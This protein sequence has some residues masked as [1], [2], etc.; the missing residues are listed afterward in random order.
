MVAEG[1]LRFGAA[2]PAD[3]RCGAIRCCRARPDPAEPCTP[4]N[5]ARDIRHLRSGRTP[6]R[7]W[8]LYWLRPPEHATLSAGRLPSLWGY[9]VARLSGSG[10]PMLISTPGRLRSVG[11]CNVSRGNTV[12]LQPCQ[13]WSRPRVSIPSRRRT[14]N[15][16]TE[17]CCGSPHRCHAR[18]AYDRAASPPDCPGR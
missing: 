8:R 4:G 6:L 18:S 5:D 7:K 13:L 14:T 12:W 10:G 15:V 11:N 16:G 17:V 1:V 3:A 9:V 2:L